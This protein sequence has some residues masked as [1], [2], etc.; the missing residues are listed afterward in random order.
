MTLNELEALVAT[1]KYKP[2]SKFKVR[3]DYPYDDINL[4]MRLMVDNVNEPSKRIELRSMNRY[5]MSLVHQWDKD[6][7]L[8]EILKLVRQMENHETDEWLTV[9]GVR[10]KEP[11][12]EEK[13]EFKMSA[14]LPNPNFD[15]ALW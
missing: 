15:E 12:P 9:E 6:R 7:A 11:H 2:G 1:I 8:Y 14:T 13:L 4:I 5:P 3:E 10:L